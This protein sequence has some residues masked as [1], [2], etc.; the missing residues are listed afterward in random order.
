MTSSDKRTKLVRHARDLL[1]S[2]TRIMA[3]ADMLDSKKS[4]RIRKDMERE[5]AYMQSST[6]QKELLEHF[7]AYGE[8]Y[9]EMMDFT[10]TTIQ[11]ASFCEVPNCTFELKVCPSVLRKNISRKKFDWG[12]LLGNKYIIPKSI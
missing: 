1:N 9:K 8:H 11:V 7:K 2:V 4:V 3:V 5:L 6:S 10:S 12:V